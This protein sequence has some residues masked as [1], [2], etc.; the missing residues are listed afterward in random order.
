LGN[1]GQII[2]ITCCFPPIRI[3]PEIIVG[4]RNSDAIADNGAG[5]TESK[6]Q[7]RFDPFFTTKPVGKG[8]GLLLCMGFS[9]HQG[10]ELQ[11]EILICQ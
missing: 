9:T 11:I 3:R 6:H 8:T 5:M 4:D 2:H 10:A 7:K 1:S